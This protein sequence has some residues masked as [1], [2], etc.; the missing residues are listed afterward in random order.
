MVIFVDMNNTSV[1][2]PYTLSALAG[3]VGNAVRMEP[4]LQG[5]WVVAELSD[6]RCSGGH[7][8]MELIE[9][10]ARGA[11][12]AKLRANLWA[13]RAQQVRAKFY[14]ATGRD[15]AS[16]IK[17]MLYGAVTHHSLYGLSF[18]I[19]DI[20]PSYTLGDLERLR[21]EILE[22]LQREGILERQRALPFPPAPQK[23]A[24]I[25]AAGAAGYGD[26]VHQIEDSPEGFRF[27]PLLYG[28]VMQGE[29]T[30]AS[31]MA[32]L[33]KIEMTLDFWDAVVIIRGGGS[34]SDLNGFDNLELARR[35]ALFP[36]PVVV[37]IGHERDRCVLDDIAKVRCKTPTA[38]AAFLID[39]M[40]GFLGRLTELTSTASRYASDRVAGDRRQLAA[41][42]GMIPALASRRVSGARLR[43]QQLV[44]TLPV[45]VAAS[46]SRRRTRLEVLGSA[47]GVSAGTQLER[48]R[49]RLAD[50]SL[51]L[52]QSSRR[53][54]EV[55]QKRLEYLQGLVGALSPENTL[56]RGYSITR[57]DGRAVRDAASLPEG[58]VLETTLASGT[59]RSVVT[60]AE[61][62]TEQ[63]DTQHDI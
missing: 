61:D 3:V 38:V 23:I 2:Q 34:T 18:N 5:L 29:R 47:L 24:V 46:T 54:V 1:P 14:A 50:I 37:G 53:P 59:V 55:Q 41:L 52:E 17:V 36:L 22:Q 25:S 57:L 43:L 4:R 16:G 30:A 56:R 40:R 45:A 49:Q 8:Y 44:A 28:A 32:A 60:G 39:R 9:K 31:V 10:D 13:G 19:G 33:D 58:T 12:V 48:R 21:R 35:V 11:T 63:Q 6:V 7:F 62:S 26:F 51:L 20:D 15:I 27:Y 42:E